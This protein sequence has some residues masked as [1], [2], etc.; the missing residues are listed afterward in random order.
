MIFLDS[1]SSASVPVFD[2]SYTHWHRGETE[3]DQS[4]EINS[5][6][7][8]YLMS[9]LYFNYPCEQWTLTSPRSEQG[10]TL[11][12]LNLWR[13]VQIFLKGD[14]KIKKSHRRLYSESYIF[15]NTSH[16]DN[17]PGWQL[18]P[19]CPCRGFRWSPSTGSG[20]IQQRTTLHV[21]IIET[22]ETKLLLDSSF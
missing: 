3:R 18:H 22:V 13:D 8:Q 5:K 4:P 11:W 21:F 20:S 6:K 1:A 14:F 7:T 9:T 10:F 12:S 19:C 17:V 2:L 16:H 15:T